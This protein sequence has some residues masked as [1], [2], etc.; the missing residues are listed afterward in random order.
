MPWGCQR[1]PRKETGI[2]NAGDLS[3]ASLAELTEASRQNLAQ[4][5]LPGVDAE[6][7]RRR[8]RSSKF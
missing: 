8:Q 2:F 3:A 4:V 6:A 1:T 5:R 7:Q